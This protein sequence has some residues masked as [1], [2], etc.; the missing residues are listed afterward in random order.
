M[1]SEY[2]V[3]PELAVSHVAKSICDVAFSMLFDDSFL[4]RF[5]INWFFGNAFKFEIDLKLHGVSSINKNIA[6]FFVC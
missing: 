1:I 3:G 2:R 5:G 6:W 4:D